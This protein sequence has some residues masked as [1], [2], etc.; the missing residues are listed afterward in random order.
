[1]VSVERTLGEGR[2][3]VRDQEHWVQLL[4]VLPGKDMLHK[5]LLSKTQINQIYTSSRHRTLPISWP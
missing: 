2:G 3:L 1:M 5:L 4:H